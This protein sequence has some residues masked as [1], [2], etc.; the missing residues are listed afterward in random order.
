MCFIDEQEKALQLLTSL[1][2]LAILGFL[3]LEEL[4]A[5]LHSLHSLERLDNIRGCP[6]ISRLPE[7]GLPPSLEALE[8]NDCSVELQEQCRMLC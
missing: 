3:N 8:I 5:V 6:R 4:P 1:Q 2:G 7:T